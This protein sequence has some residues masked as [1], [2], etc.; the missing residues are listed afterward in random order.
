M[1]TTYEG[2]RNRETWSVA[3]QIDNDYE[4]YQAKEGIKSKEPFTADSAKKFAKEIL[5]GRTPGN[6]DW[7]EIADH[8]NAD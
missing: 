3:L 6:V 4:M 7:D 8:W 5:G 1:N 2:W